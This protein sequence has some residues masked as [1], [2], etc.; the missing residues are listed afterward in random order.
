MAPSIRRDLYA[1]VTSRIAE[2]EAASRDAASA[3]TGLTPNH[4]SDRWSRLPHPIRGTR[5]RQGG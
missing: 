3:S 4:G 5:T 1:D 2:L